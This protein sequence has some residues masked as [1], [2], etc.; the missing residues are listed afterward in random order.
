MVKVS[1]CG[2]IFGLDSQFLLLAVTLGKLLNIFV[3]QFTHPRDGI[4]VLSTEDS[5]EVGS[6]MC[7][8]VNSYLNINITIVP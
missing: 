5:C 4:I 3:S 6:C 2:I 8:L 1:G 7:L